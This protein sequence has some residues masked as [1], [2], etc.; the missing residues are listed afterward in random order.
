[1]NGINQMQLKLMAT[2][3]DNLHSMGFPAYQWNYCIYN[4]S[5]TLQT[6]LI[7]SFNQPP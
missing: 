3:W 5:T 1:M 6:Q 4:L 7:G 2:V